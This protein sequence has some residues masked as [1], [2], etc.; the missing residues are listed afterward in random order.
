MPTHTRSH[1]RIRAAL[2]AALGGAA[3]APGA[4]CSFFTTVPWPTTTFA[5]E[6]LP[7]GGEERLEAVFERHG[8]SW[9]KEGRTNVVYAVDG[10]GGAW[11]FRTVAA[12]LQHTINKHDLDVRL[13][14]VRLDY[15]GVTARGGE[16]ETFISVTATPGA[17]IW[18]ADRD[19]AAPWRRATGVQ[20]GEWRGEVRTDGVVADVGGWVYAA[21]V[22]GESVR[23]LRINV[24]T[25]A[26]ERVLGRDLPFAEPPAD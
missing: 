5:F 8:L 16:T 3:L 20:R 18:I 7:S 14:T 13:V 25:R 12:R 22:A 2:A 6:G 26:E 11:E 21:V 15:F 10:I 9:E 19:R 24:V 17:V 4:G 23:Y 1:A